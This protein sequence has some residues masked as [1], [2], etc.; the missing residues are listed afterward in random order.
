MSSFH[1]LGTK[2][3]SE[4][5]FFVFWNEL[6]DGN[7]AYTQI[8]LCFTHLITQPEGKVMQCSQHVSV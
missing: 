7:Q 2:S 8:H 5:I 4:F 1:M 6:E 3:V